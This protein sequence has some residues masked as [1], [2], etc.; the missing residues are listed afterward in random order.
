[1]E[2]TVMVCV[3]L[4]FMQPRRPGCPGRVGACS[5]QGRWRCARVAL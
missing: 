2:S 4:K 1:M 5:L 3:M